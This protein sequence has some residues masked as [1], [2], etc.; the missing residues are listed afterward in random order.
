LRRRLILTA[1]GRGAAKKGKASAPSLS[2]ECG[3]RNQ[4]IIG[5]KSSTWE[6]GGVTARLR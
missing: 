3:L 5:S 4:A 2:D 6:F 1:S